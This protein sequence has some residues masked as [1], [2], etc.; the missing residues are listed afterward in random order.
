[1]ALRVKRNLHVIEQKHLGITININEIAV[2]NYKRN[3]GRQLFY[4]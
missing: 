1:M 3:I 4:P 2:Q